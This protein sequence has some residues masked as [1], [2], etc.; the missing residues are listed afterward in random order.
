LRTDQNACELPIHIA[1]RT[2]SLSLVAYLLNKD[3]TQVRQV[4]NR[5]YTALHLASEGNHSQVVE[6]LLSIGAEVNA[7]GTD[8]WTPL[9]LA[10]SEGHLEVASLL[11]ESGSALEC[12]TW[13]Q[14]TPLILAVKRRHV[15]MIEFLLHKKA[16]PNAK[17]NL[18]MAPLHIASVLGFEDVTETLLSESKCQVTSTC[19]CN[20]TPLHYAAGNGAAGIAKQLIKADPQVLSL[21]GGSFNESNPMSDIFKK[22]LEGSTPLHLACFAGHLQIARILATSGAALSTANTCGRTPLM[23]AAR[24]GHIQ[25][26]RLLLNQGARLDKKFLKRDSEFYNSLY[27]KGQHDMLALLE[28]PKKASLEKSMDVSISICNGIT[29][30]DPLPKKLFSSSGLI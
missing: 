25:I 20:L 16:N 23:L 18:E 19:N 2:G 22:D 7:S 30:L 1:A 11:V 24:E 17:T 8:G 28:E 5:E 26:V 14:C 12:R 6:I 13:D 15:P 9:H 21:P 27:E 4:N 10:A 29:K 3:R